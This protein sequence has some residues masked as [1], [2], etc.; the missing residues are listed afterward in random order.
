MEGKIKKELVK[1]NQVGSRRKICRIMKKLGLVSKYTVA[2]FSPLIPNV[3][4]LT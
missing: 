2:Q 4:S 3:M 1:E